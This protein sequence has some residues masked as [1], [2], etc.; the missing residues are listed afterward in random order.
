MNPLVIAA[1]LLLL[2]WLVLPRASGYGAYAP[3]GPYDLAYG[4]GYGIDGLY[5][6]A[7]P[8]CMNP[9]GCVAQN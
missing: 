2:L 8:P 7:V 6:L 4:T 5:K 9:E 1:V 3:W